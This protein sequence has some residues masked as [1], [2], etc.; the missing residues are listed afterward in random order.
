MKKDYPDYI[1]Q[2]YSNAANITNRNYRE[3]PKE[4]DEDDFNLPF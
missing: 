1:Q 3:P 4:I 2:F